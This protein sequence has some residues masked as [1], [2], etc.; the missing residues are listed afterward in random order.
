M[1]KKQNLNIQPITPLI[2]SFLISLVT[3]IVSNY[4]IQLPIRDT[5]IFITLSFVVVLQ[6]NQLYE[7][8][9]I[10]NRLDGIITLTSLFMK[11]F[12]GIQEKLMQLPQDKSILTSDLINILSHPLHDLF[13]GTSQAFIDL[14]LKSSSPEEHEEIRILIEKANRNEIS[15]AEAELLRRLLET[16]RKR[17][18]N[19]GDILGA[20]VV[21]VLICLLLGLI[22]S[23]FTEEE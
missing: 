6:I 13:K 11:T 15:R 16:E 20:L 19:A 18:E 23:L 21:G 14:V 3:F 4:I 2:I 5:L 8:G 7:L 10:R 12:E 1:K 22:A 17:R 9:G